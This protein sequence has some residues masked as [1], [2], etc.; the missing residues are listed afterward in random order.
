MKPSLQLIRLSRQRNPLQRRKT[1][2]IP[3]HHV[4]LPRPLAERNRD[5]P[6][7]STIKPPGPHQR[8]TLRHGL[9]RLVINPHHRPRRLLRHQMPQLSLPNQRPTAPPTPDELHNPHAALPLQLR[10]LI[11][12][13]PPL[14]RCLPVLMRLLTVSRQPVQIQ[15]RVHLRPGRAVHMLRIDLIHLHQ[16]LR[17]VLHVQINTHIVRRPPRPRHRRIKIQIHPILQR[18]IRPRRQRRNPL[19]R[20]RRPRHQSRLRMH[21]RQPPGFQIRRILLRRLRPRQR[22]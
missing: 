7:F 15:I 10:K 13:L 17:H 1:A 4:L 16:Q 5:Q 6:A 14:Q 12:P 19:R 3:Q 11:R 2:P 22:R 8:I 9:H 20:I 18:L 21:R